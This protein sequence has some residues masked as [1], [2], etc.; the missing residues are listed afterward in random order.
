LTNSEFPE[1][2][3]QGD[4]GQ[5][6]GEP[7]ATGLADA[8]LPDTDL[9][10]AGF[11]GDA[12][13]EPVIEAS[14]GDEGEPG[15]GELPE[16]IDIPGEAGLPA[17]SQDEW[18]AP[19]SDDDIFVA[20]SDF[21]DA[22]IE[23][24]EFEPENVSCGAVFDDPVTVSDEE[25]AFLSKLPGGAAGITDEGSVFEDQIVFEDEVGSTEQSAAEEDIDDTPTE[26]MF[27][28]QWGEAAAEAIE[29]TSP[30]QFAP[31]ASVSTSL[32][33]NLMEQVKTVLTYMDQ[34]LEN[35]PEEKIEEFARS[36]H[37]ESYK[38]LFDE[39]GIS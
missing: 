7:P 1:F 5:V 17:M 33:Q 6:A 31:G 37:F 34:L 35:L 26:K 36:E 30:A 28:E 24:A 39:L 16:E 11:D 27:G 21:N 9:S 2:H 19:K 22:E 23:G 32:D 13:D 18:Q 25:E 38:K 4:A 8:G 29:E 3:E 10:D 15:A 12:R 20:S 14:G